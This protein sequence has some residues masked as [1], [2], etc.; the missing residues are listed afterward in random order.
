MYQ[1]QIR[2]IQEAI[3]AADYALDCLYEAQDCL[4]SARNWGVIDILGGG[5]ISTFIKRSRMRDA[6]RCIEDAKAAMATFRK[7]LADVDR[8]MPLAIDE[9]DFW[10]FADYFFDGFIADFMVQSQIARAREQVD[11]AISRVKEIRSQLQRAL[12]EG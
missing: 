10:S 8:A 9:Y 3:N 1:E 7:E 12:S 11:E 6:S 4:G 5:F 2:E